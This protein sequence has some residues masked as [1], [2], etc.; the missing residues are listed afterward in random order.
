METKIHL[1]PFENELVQNSEWI[2]A[3]RS[4]IEK[5]YHLFAGLMEEYNKTLIEN[6]PGFDFLLKRNGKI[7][8]GENYHGLPYVIMDYPA[9]FEK[10]DVFAIRTFFWW[11]NFFSITLHLSGKH[12]YALN[13]DKAFSFLK[14]KEFFICV[15]KDEWNHTFEEANYIPATQAR[16]IQKNTILEGRFL[17][18]SK[19]VGLKEWDEAAE[20]LGKTFGEI[21]NLI[22]VS[23]RYDGAGP[24]PGLPRE[25]S[26]L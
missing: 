6:F 5:V 21:M 7:S 20:F 2:L 11:G 15:N 16:E 8:R 26:D 23:F 3:K 1:S 24:L 17:K 9:A 4:V 19:R 22:R 25:G 14:E 12:F 13:F 10:H 18:I